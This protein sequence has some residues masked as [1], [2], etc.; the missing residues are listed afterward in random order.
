MVCSG[1][2]VAWFH[3]RVMMHGL[4]WSVCCLVPCP[5]GD[6]WLVSVSVLMH[7]LIPC[8]DEWLVLVSVVMHSLSLC[9]DAWLVPV[10]VLPGS[11]SMW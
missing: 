1:Q 10:S 3:V 4:F 5:C 2:Y 11:M 6:A 7:S 8:G 9:G